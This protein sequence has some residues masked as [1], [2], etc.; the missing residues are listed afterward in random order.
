MIHEGYYVNVLLGSQL[1]GCH[2]ATTSNNFA[3]TQMKKWLEICSVKPDLDCTEL[4]QSFPNLILALA[5][6]PQ[7]AA[8]QRAHESALC[9][10]A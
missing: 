6:E 9:P 3:Q 10:A 1:A 5:L 7:R 2:A 8:S 4:C